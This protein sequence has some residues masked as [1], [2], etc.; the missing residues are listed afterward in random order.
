[1]KNNDSKSSIVLLTLLSAFLFCSM[2]V[3][4]SLS[5]LADLGTNTNQFGDIGMWS[6]VGFVLILFLLP[7]ILFFNLSF[8]R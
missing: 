6:A 7:L 4:G 3:V 1:M 2:I 8:P 5:P